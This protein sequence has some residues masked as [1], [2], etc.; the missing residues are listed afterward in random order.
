M[1]EFFRS[2]WFW[3]T[4]LGSLIG[5]GMVGHRTEIVI[6]PP[7]VPAIA[8]D[9]DGTRNAWLD[10]DGNEIL[11]AIEEDTYEWCDD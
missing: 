11:L 1:R 7:C 9:Y 2:P 8:V 10:A 4:F 3:G 5:W 6:A